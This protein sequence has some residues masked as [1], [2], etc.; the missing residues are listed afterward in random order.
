MNTA[1]FK[2]HKT[3]DCLIT[4]LTIFWGF[5]VQSYFNQTFTSTQNVSPNTVYCSVSP[6]PFCFNKYITGLGSTENGGN[7][8]PRNL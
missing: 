4:T 8:R 3:P 2:G 6:I 1:I 5:C 7:P